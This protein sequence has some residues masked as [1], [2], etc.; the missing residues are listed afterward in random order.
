MLQDAPAVGPPPTSPSA[1]DKEALI[2][3]F[4][5]P[6]TLHNRVR[7]WNPGVTFFVLAAMAA[8]AASRGGFLWPVVIIALYVVWAFVGGVGGT[9][10]LTY[11][12]LALLIGGVFFLARSLVLPGEHVL[13]T[14]G[15]LEVSEESL[16]A[17]GAFAL[18]L[19]ALSGALI[20]LFNLVPVK[21]MM[22]ALEQVGV[23]PRVTFVV[24]AS[25]QSIAD[26][27]ANSKVIA[28]AQES[29]GI[30]MGGSPGRKV[31]A[32]FSIITPVF[33]TAMS[34]TEE[35]ALALDARAFGAPTKHTHL[36]QIKRA[37]VAQKILVSV[38]LVVA[39]LS[40]L[41]AATSWF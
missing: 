18:T 37:S 5:E 21:N 28:A 38:S 15:G 26:L 1:I 31:K 27:G 7:D 34:D 40:I 2:A 20:L 4:R 30:E 33:L 12:R 41:G 36:V 17:A 29:R 24:L 11:S 22:L 16:L 32:F 6:S 10:L 14:F 39:V 8:F 13:W 19:V 23:S 9:F 25:Y 35:R 3:R